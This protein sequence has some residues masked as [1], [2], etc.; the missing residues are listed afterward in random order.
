MNKKH[1]K[2][3]II[4]IY[5]DGWLSV[6]ELSKLVGLSH[7]TMGHVLDPESKKGMSFK[8][9]RKIRDYLEEIKDEVCK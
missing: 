4:K 2:D 8:T 7:T 3:A 5:F 9:V 6:H 1:Y